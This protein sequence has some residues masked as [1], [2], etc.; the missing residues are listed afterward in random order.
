MNRRVVF[1]FGP[2]LVLDL[3]GCNPKKLKDEVF[4]RRLLDELPGHIRMTKIQDPQVIYY[5]GGGEGSF[6][7][8]GI[9]GF[10]LIAESHI[11]IHT[12]VE[13]GHAFIDIF[14]CKE[15]DIE[16]AVKYL[17][18]AL[19]AKKVD[20]QVFSRGREFPKEVSAVEKIVE[21]DRKAFE[22]DEFGIVLKEE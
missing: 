21:N 19:E 6:D 9:S 15:F 4:I 22:D 16:K 8:G 14:S 12:F 18:D 3:H 20:K 13:Q 2:Q 11:A 17:T 7:K 1:G 10:V 5:P